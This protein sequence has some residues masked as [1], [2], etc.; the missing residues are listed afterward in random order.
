MRRSS[1][2][3]STAWRWLKVPRPTSWPLRRTRSPSSTSDPKASAS[4][5]PQSMAPPSRTIAA[6]ASIMRSDLGVRVKALGHAR[7]RAG[8]LV[9]HRRRRRRSRRSSRRRPSRD[10]FHS[11][12]NAKHLLARH[13][14]AR[15]ALGVVEQLAEL[16]SMRRSAS[17]AV[18]TPVGHEARRGTARAAT[19]AGA[20]CAVH[21]RLR[22]ASGRRARCGRACGSRRGR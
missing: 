16:A 8:D 19:G 22:E 13:E 4:P 14:V 6:R 5:Q 21:H 11:P 3:C 17:S 12:P 20:I 1:T 2:S 15:V 7:E 18:S 9:E 10:P